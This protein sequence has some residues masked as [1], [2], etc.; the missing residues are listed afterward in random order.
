MEHVR[1]P[2]AVINCLRGSTIQT[3]Y[4]GK[5]VSLALT[6]E[7]LSNLRQVRELYWKAFRQVDM[8]GHA[9]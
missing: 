5:A 1:G 3:T 9:R 2:I 6:E 8:L 7:S 4:E